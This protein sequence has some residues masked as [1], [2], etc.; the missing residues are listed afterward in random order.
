MYR[1]LGADLT[2]YQEIVTVLREDIVR[3]RYR[4]NAQLPS[5]ADLGGRFGASRG[6]VRKAIDVLRAEHLVRAQRGSGTYVAASSPISSF[7]TLSTFEQDIR[8]LG[9]TPT[10]RLLTAAEGP[11]TG[12]EAGRLGLGGGAPVVRVARLRL[13]DGTPLAHEERVF[14]ADLC[15]GILDEDLENQS[16]YWLITTKYAIPIVRIQHVVDVRPLRAAEA[17]VLKTVEG[18]LGYAVDRLTF[19]TDLR[20][21]VWFRSLHRDPQGATP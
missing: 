19:T 12:D 9:K 7:F 6:T 8:A 1:Q 11:A 4:P 2:K 18:E 14:A 5:E 13:A 15:P 21:A 3:G 10:S 20:P 17:S 16:L